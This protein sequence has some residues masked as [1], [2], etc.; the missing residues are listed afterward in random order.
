MVTV[1]VESER[2]IANVREIAAVPGV[3]VVLVGPGDLMIDVRA[4]G[5]DERHHE[6]LVL[7]VAAAAKQAGKAAGYV[8]PDAATVEQ[9]MAQG[10]RFLC[11]GFD[12]DLMQRVLRSMSAQVAAWSGAAG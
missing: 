1:M 3:D 12:A 6:E 2:A 8:C 11:Y 9:R 5:H 4:Q 7:E 10:F